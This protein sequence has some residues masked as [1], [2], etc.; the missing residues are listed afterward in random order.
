MKTFEEISINENGQK[1]TYRLYKYE[2]I[3]VRKIKKP[4]TRLNK[5]SL[6]VGFNYEHDK[7]KVVKYA[8]HQEI[9]K[10]G[11]FQEKLICE[12]ESYATILTIIKGILNEYINIIN[13]M[14]T[15][16]T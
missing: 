11:D 4:A 7:V 13:Q 1:C 5:F 16:K 6:N 9:E 10:N 12:T 3:A 15:P 2:E 14:Q 8:L